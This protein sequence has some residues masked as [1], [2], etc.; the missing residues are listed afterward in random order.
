MNNLFWEAGDIRLFYREI[1]SMA[2]STMLD[3]SSLEPIIIS[4][5]DSDR[6]FNADISYPILVLVDGDDLVSILDG[7][8]RV[9][10]AL[11]MS[12][13]QLPSLVVDIKCD[14]R[15]KILK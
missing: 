1:K 10:K 3:V 15:L 13:E 5:I 6:V 2:K 14:D 7:N 11:E 9:V 12:V 8:H 4:N